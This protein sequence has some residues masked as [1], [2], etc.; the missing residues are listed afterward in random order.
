MLQSS[1][2]EGGQTENRRNSK[3]EDK[4]DENLGDLGPKLLHIEFNSMYW[5]D[6][7]FVA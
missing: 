7:M 2:R 1:G 3:G 4:A 6:H 5:N